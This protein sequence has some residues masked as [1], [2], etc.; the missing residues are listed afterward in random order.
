MLDTANELLERSDELAE[1]IDVDGT[2]DL[3]DVSVPEPAVRQEARSAKTPSAKAA[4][5]ALSAEDLFA[6]EISRTSLLSRAEEE[7]LAGKIVRTRKRVLAIL[8]KAPRLSR[9]ALTNAGRRVVPLEDGFRER[10]ALLILEHARR[11]TQDRR[12]AREIRMPVK[13]LRSFVKALSGALA[14]YHIHRNEMVRA[15]VRLVRVLARRYHHADLTFLDLFQEGTLGLLR[16]IEKYEPSRKVKFST[17]ASWWIWQQLGRAGD[18]YGSLVR[19]PVHW[20]QFRR[21]VRRQAQELASENDGVASRSQ[22]AELE[23]VDSERFETMANAFQFISTDAPLGDEDDRPLHT[24][25]PSPAPGPEEYAQRRNLGNQLEEAL[26][27]LPQRENFILRQ[28]FGL[29][30]DESHTLEELGT[31]LGVS[32]ERVRQLEARALKQLKEIGAQQGLQD[33]LN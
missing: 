27:H 14:E 3:F 23:G 24:T 2:D 25:L 11:A 12:L 13:E 19:T 15:N 9:S 28:R 20:H 26:Q 5:K 8:R 31:V 6:A 22:L 18:T 30:A 1:G 7:E 21:R 33:F 17:Y 32:R 16:A 4:S 10:E 29:D